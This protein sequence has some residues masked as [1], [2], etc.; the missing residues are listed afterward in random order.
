[1]R[2]HFIWDVIEM[3]RL[4]ALILALSFLLCFAGCNKEDEDAP[5][6]TKTKS[7][8]PVTEASD[9][10]DT[11]KSNSTGTGSYVAGGNTAGSYV[12]G[13]QASNN[14]TAQ[15]SANSQQQVQQQPQQQAQQQQPQQ[16][17][18][19]QQQPQQQGQQQQQQTPVI[20]ID[21]N[22][23]LDDTG[24]VVASLIPDEE[25]ISALMSTGGSIAGSVMATIYNNMTPER[26]QKVKEALA[27][28]SDS[29]GKVDTSQF[30]SLISSLF[31][32]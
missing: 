27:T 29:T 17:A 26:Q 31:K 11:T 30:S 25:V 5:S 14:K 10:S 28:A 21:V 8:M 23:I 22:E 20:S 9:E 7:V 18:Q 19:Q 13:G 1:M 32:R 3:K 6:S 2:A 4:I 16:Q 12:S 15:G 24:N